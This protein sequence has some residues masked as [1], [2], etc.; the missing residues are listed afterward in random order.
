MAAGIFDG[1]KVKRQILTAAPSIAEQLLLVD[2][3][4]RAGRGTAPKPGQ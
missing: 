2:E 1:Y 3:I 4:M